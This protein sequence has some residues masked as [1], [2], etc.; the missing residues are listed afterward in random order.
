M[1]NYTIQSGSHDFL[2]TLHSN[3]RSIS[4]RFWD[5]RPFA[6]EIQRKSKIFPNTCVYNSPCWRGSPWDWLSVHGCY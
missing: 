2:L 1:E 5:K 4:H 6:P 3:C